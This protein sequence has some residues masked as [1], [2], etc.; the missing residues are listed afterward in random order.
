MLTSRR[1]VHEVAT[2]NFTA[3]AFTTPTRMPATNPGG[4]PV[5]Q[6]HRIPEAMLTSRRQVHGVAQE[7]HGGIAFFTSPARGLGPRR[8]DQG[9]PSGI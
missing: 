2:E 9:L 1:Q 3:A 5:R 6:R 7:N 8:A 4:V